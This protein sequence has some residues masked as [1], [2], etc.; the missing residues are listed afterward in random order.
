MPVPNTNTFSLS[1]VTTEI[2]L[3]STATLGDC[4]NNATGAGFDATYGSITDNNMLAFRN[5]NH[6][7]VRTL[8][9][10][11]SSQS[12]GA[13]SGSF[14]L[15]IT[16]TESWTISDTSGGYLSYSPISGT[17]DTVVTVSY[18][19]SG[20]PRSATITVSTTSGSPILT[21]NCAFEQVP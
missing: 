14:D 7:T 12:V 13:S 6:S 19:S 17:G 20:S 21:D 2:G 18:T 16:S 8:S 9:I 15:T 1:D 11:P 10:S 3:G 5:Y 4:F